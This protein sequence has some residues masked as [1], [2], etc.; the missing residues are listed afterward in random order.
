MAL[1][2]EGGLV[3]L[4]VKQAADSVTTQEHPHTG[5]EDRLTPHPRPQVSMLSP[6]R[7]PSPA[8]TTNRKAAS[9]DGGR[10][11]WDQTLLGGQKGR[12]STQSTWW[13]ESPTVTSSAI[14]ESNLTFP[15]LSTLT[16]E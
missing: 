7:A 13:C 8:S 4:T 9:V 14:S 2:S 10:R 6:L 16:E 3:G 1:S 11:R 5:A 12:G 15:H